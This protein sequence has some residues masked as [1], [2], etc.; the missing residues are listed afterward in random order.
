[1]DAGGRGF[2]LH[3]EDLSDRRERQRAVSVEE[4]TWQRRGIKDKTYGGGSVF[5]VPTTHERGKAWHGNLGDCLCKQPIIDSSNGRGA[6]VV[7]FVG[8]GLGG[9]G[10]N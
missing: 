9:T 5:K 3:N 8:R 10:T 1:M 4:K 2:A 7:C 6:R